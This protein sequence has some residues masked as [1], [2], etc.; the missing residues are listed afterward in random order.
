MTNAKKI[1]ILIGI[2]FI[3]FLIY[4]LYNSFNSRSIEVSQ[5]PFIGEYFTGDIAISP[6][7]KTIAYS[8][9][10]NNGNVDIY[11]SDINGKGGNLL[12]KPVANEKHIIQSYSPDGTK[13]LFLTHKKDGDGFISYIHELG[14]KNNTQEQ[15]TNEKQKI[16]KAIYSLDGKKIYYL[17]YGYFGNYDGIA[18]PKAHDYDV[19]SINIDGSS[20]K[21]LT[22][23][24]NY[25]LSSLSI[26]AS[27]TKLFFKGTKGTKDTFY[28]LNLS[29]LALNNFLPKGNFTN[30]I[31][32]NPQISKNGYFVFTTVSSDT[33]GFKYD[34]FGV[35]LTKDD[36]K[37]PFEYDGNY[38]PTK[39]VTQIT[40]LHSNVFSPRFFNNSNA[41][42]LVQD[43][44]WPNSNNP[45]PNYQLLKVNLDNLGNEK[46]VLEEPNKKNDIKK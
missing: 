4:K 43:L 16:S 29:D 11:S 33:Y 7:D 18:Q 30:K 21:K 38:V 31:F 34:L 42:L 5:Q 32:N 44:N 36:N 41:L 8:Y 26:N 1:F 22:S 20:E 14:I 9:H 28:E 2:L 17:K 23:L 40:D 24:N 27:G 10:E 39:S 15:I 13:I 37:N 3:F 45:S 19:F 25:G 6:D 12:T 46:I 35:D